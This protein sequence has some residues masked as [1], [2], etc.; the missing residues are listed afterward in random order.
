MR[1][2][3][4]SMHPVVRLRLVVPVF[5]NDCRRTRP[6]TIRAQHGRRHRAPDGEQD[7]QQDQDEDAEVIHDE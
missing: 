1:R 3:V 2:R 4:I 5:S 6:L 7:G